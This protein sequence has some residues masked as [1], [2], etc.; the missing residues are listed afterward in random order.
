[1]GP[2]FLSGKYHTA[3]SKAESSEQSVTACRRMCRRLPRTA[4]GI[5]M[6]ITLMVCAYQ[7][8]AMAVAT[9]AGDGRQVPA[10][11]SG[12][13]TLVTPN[14]GAEAVT[15]NQD[16]APVG[17]AILASILPAGYNYPRT[18]ATLSVAGLLPNR[19]YAVHVH[20]NACGATGEAAGPHYQN[21]V[22]P[23]AS[24]QAPSTD[25]EY[26]NPGNEIWLDVST[27]ATGSGSARAVVPF[28]FTDRVPGSIV[29][30]DAMTTATAPGQAGTAGARIACLTLSR[31]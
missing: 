21:R 5:T 23:A 18:A 9:L 22:D 13:D 20:T 14:Q 12:S 24:P 3:Y 25:P 16:L 29:V 19:G 2:L 4:V 1:M 31:Q 26:A 30:H 8:P 10:T 11:L 27:N 7:V 17:A 6:A 28:T 15:Y